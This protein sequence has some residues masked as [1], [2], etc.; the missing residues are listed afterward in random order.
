MKKKKHWRHTNKILACVHNCKQRCYTHS[1]NAV[2]VAFFMFF[3]FPL[4]KFYQTTIFI[5]M[6]RYDFFLCND[7]TTENVVWMYTITMNIE[8]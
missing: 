3:V 4:C 6:D 1:I 8:G 5:D 2:V 7:N